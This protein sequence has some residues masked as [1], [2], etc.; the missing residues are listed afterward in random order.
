MLLSSRVGR[1]FLWVMAK[2]LLDDPAILSSATF[3]SYMSRIKRW[4]RAF[5]K[6]CYDDSEVNRTLARY[7]KRLPVQGLFRKIFGQICE[8]F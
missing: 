3:H 1:P 7:A 2:D 6:Y 4:I 5:K 8:N